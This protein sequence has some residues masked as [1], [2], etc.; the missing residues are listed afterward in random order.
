MVLEAV[1]TPLPAVIAA[2]ASVID[3][4][5]TRKVISEGATTVYLRA[6]TS[7]L[8]GRIAEDAVRP[9]LGDVGKEIAALNGPAGRSTRSLL[10]SSSTS[11]DALPLTS[12]RA[13]SRR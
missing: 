3:D 8:V 9:V 4:D 7:T 12:P 13:S 6:S 10:T 5:A 11:T 1:A 2:A